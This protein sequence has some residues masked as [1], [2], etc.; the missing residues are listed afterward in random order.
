VNKGTSK[1][2]KK[3]IIVA[4]ERPEPLEEEKY[5]TNSSKQAK[6]EDYPELDGV[7]GS[8]QAFNPRNDNLWKTI[9]TQPIKQNKKKD[10]S[11]TYNLH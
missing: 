2:G 11:Q 8:S 10:D 1:K 4:N 7:S 6:T 5:D 3:M 9:N